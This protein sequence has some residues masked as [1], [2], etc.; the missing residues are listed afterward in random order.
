MRFIKRYWKDAATWIFAVLVG[1]LLFECHE[2]VS[3]EYH[4][5][6]IERGEKP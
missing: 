2:K 3:F 5:Q 1:H 6:M 4:K